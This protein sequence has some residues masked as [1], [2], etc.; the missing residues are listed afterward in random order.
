M[1]QEKKVRKLEVMDWDP[2]RYL[3]TEGRQRAYIEEVIKENPN[4]KAAILSALADVA[5][6]R[7]MGMTQ[8][9]RETGLRRDSLYKALSGNG[10]P[11]LDTLVR[12]A[13]ALGV[14]IQ[15]AVMPP[16]DEKKTA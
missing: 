8:L 5:R 11:T 12:I 3:H 4:D 15:L 7:Q 16:T 14:V 9:A 2:A 1:G 10:N 13:K 6:A